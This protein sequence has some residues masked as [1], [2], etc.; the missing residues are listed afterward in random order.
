[1]AMIDTGLFFLMSGM[2]FFFLF[3]SFTRDNGFASGLFKL[4]A[5]LMFTVL[6]L[7]MAAGYQVGETETIT[8]NTGKSYTSIKFLIQDHSDWIGAVFYLLGLVSLL[9]FIWKAMRGD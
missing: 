8:D 3:F 4:I 9:A 2:G 7:Y 1:M 6:G 5:F